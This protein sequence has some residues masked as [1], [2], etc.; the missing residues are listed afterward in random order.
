MKVIPLSLDLCYQRLLCAVFG[1]DKSKPIKLLQ[2]SIRAKFEWQERNR[3]RKNTYFRIHGAKT[4]SYEGNFTPSEWLDRLEEFN[5]C[6]AYCLKPL[7]NKA[8]ADHIVPISKGGKN[9][10]SN[11][12]PACQSC[13][14]HKH[15][16][17]L[18]SF[19]S[20]GLTN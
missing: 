12:V 15:N 5:N 1:T 9:Y 10:I 8:T 20:A 19:I 14:S 6:C 2:A 17:S 13:N 16:K 3:I 7:G 4:Q 18:L 11:I